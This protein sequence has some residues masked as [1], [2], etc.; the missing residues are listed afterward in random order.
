MNRSYLTVLAKPLL[1]LVPM[2]LVSCGGDEYADDGN[3]FQAADPKKANNY[4]FQGQG[5]TKYADGSGAP[6][7]ATKPEGE[8]PAD[9]GNAAATSGDGSTP[10]ATAGTTSTD[11]VAQEPVAPPAPVQTKPKPTSGLPFGIPVIGNKGYVYSPY[12]PEKG[13]VDVRE[14]NSGVKVECPYTF[15]HFRVP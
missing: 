9:G 12:A 6:A 5:G 15:K 11:P 4:G 13:M 10:P 3:I 1:F 7:D 14:L 2:V 8:T